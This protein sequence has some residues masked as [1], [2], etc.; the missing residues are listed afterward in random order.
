MK[1]RRTDS[2]LR[3]L[4][5]S[6]ALLAIASPALAQTVPLETITING[7]RGDD[8]IDIAPTATPLEALQPTSVITQDFITK[9]LPM[10]AN[11]D[12]AIKFSPSVFDTAPNGPGLAESQN[13]P[14]RGFQDGQ[15]NVTFDG[16]PI[17]DSNDFTH[18]TTSYFATHD[19]GQVNVDRGPGTASTIGNATFGGTVSTLSKAPTDQLGLNPYLMYGSYNTLLYGA[20]FDS[21]EIAET[22][23]TR[24]MTDLQTQT[25]DGYLTNESQARLN[26]FIKVV[27]PLDANTTLTAVGMYNQVRQ[28]IGLGATAAQIAQFGPDYGLS[29][30]PTQQNFDGY[31]ND[32]ITTDLEYLDLKS[33][34]GDRWSLDT[35]LYTYAYFHRGLNGEDPNG[36]FPNTVSLDGV[37]NIAGVPGQ[38]LQNDYR[39][40]G[41]ITRLTKAFDFGD[42]QAGVWYDHQYNARALR[43]VD[44][45]IPSLPLNL[46]DADTGATNGLDRLLTQNLQTFQPYVQ[47]DWNITD[48]L[49][50]TPG[51]RY[52]YFDRS[53]NA[54]VNVK[55]GA[56]QSYDNTF[57]TLLPSISAHYTFTPNWTA[58]AQV[59]AGALAPNENF[60]NHTTP[61]TTSL[62][63]EKTWNYQIGTA[64]QLP[65]LTLSAD[66]YYIAFTNFDAT[67]VV[68]GQTVYFNLGGVKYMGLEAEATYMIGD[69]F[70]LYANGSLNSA[71]DNI[72]HQWIPNAPE[73]TGAIGGIYSK[74]GLYASLL[75]KWV[76]SRFGDAGQTQGLQPIFTLDGSVS[77]E[78]SHIFENIKQTTVQLQVDNITDT[79]KIINLAGYTVGA[80]TPLYWTQPSR[81]VFFTV[82]TSF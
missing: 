16:I 6:S 39:S 37:T 60:F 29:T 57:G 22:G 69:G 11:Y 48:A 28:N 17:G 31:N 45:S 38:V 33:S 34:F 12:E 59:A 66:A 41:T 61:E 62:S 49:S 10:T 65:D 81:S 8:A 2:L 26:A 47:L 18:H 50:I 74:D 27:Q 15:F 73:T 80:G 58:Y 7:Q 75:G 78:L 32:H 82:Q 23:G 40:F 72:T 1:L 68:G 70:S 3:I 20:E 46:D 52:M 79:T 55:T 77:Y 67:K 76:G 13:I 56:A 25:S 21:G 43:E 14:I 42:V 9:N 30:D 53:V 63:P 71:K 36:E 24:I 5:S 64:V 19:V 44:M 54:A 35:K 4:L 51:L